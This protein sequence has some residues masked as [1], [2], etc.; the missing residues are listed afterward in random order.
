M[1]MFKTFF[2]KFIPLILLVILLTSCNEITNNDENL[3]TT[4]EITTETSANENALIPF[5]DFEVSTQNG[6][7][8][9]T[10]YQDAMED[11]YYTI[12]ILNGNVLE[13]QSGNGFVKSAYGE[14]SD[15]DTLDG[16][17]SS[18]DDDDDFESDISDKEENQEEKLDID[19]MLGNRGEW[20]FKC[21]SEGTDY[22][23]VK[24]IT[25][26]G[27]VRFKC[28]YTCIVDTHLE[29]HMYY[30]NINY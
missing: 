7:S 15:G 21:V 3:V 20:T 26:D 14:F 11:C 29:A 27:D 9:V 28:Q 17:L 1:L 5:T 23:E 4:T 25:K 30:T 2:A 13:F 24:L 6:E 16:E 10:I 12:S 22:I 18:N 8:F 19:S